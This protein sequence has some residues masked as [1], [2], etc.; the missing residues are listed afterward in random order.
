MSQPVMLELEAPLKIGGNLLTN[1]YEKVMYMGNIMIY[2]DY[3]SMENSPQIRIICF[4]E[5]TLIVE[6]KTR[7]RSVYY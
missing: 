1:L 6:S 7:K 5:I 4:R 2:L 3:L